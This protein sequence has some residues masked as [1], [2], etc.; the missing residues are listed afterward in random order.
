MRT[1]AAAIAIILALA[2]GSPS[3]AA[4]WTQGESQSDG[5]LVQE[6]HCVPAGS[7]PF[8]AVIMLHGAGPRDMGTSDFEDFCS[9]LAEH[10]YY[11]EFIEYYSQTEPASSG[12]VAGMVRDFPTWL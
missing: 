5:K 10:G 11:T 7:G 3:H 8:P 2:I 12:D 6:N 1:V 4:R 9:K